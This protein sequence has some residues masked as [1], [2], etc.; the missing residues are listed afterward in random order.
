MGVGISQENATQGTHLFKSLFCCPVL[1]D[2]LRSGPL[3]QEKKINKVMSNVTLRKF[4][5][6]PGPLSATH[7]S[8][9]SCLAFNLEMNKPPLSPLLN[10]QALSETQ[11]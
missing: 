5:I 1:P 6:K 4:S 9:A 7:V 8:K 11:G 3:G 10:S 2:A